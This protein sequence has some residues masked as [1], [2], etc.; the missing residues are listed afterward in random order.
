MERRDE[1]MRRGKGR[2]EREEMGGG[3]GVREWT[4]YTQDTISHYTLVHSIHDLQLLKLQ[5]TT[6]RSGG[7]S[8]FIINKVV[9]R[10]G[11]LDRS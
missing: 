11:Y 8:S 6:A 3:K 7:V 9:Y 10:R 5:H 4:E 2:G 1:G